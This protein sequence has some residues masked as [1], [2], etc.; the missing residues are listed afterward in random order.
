MAIRPADIPGPL[1]P[2]SGVSDTN[3]SM[4]RDAR[5]RTS[6]G[7]HRDGSEEPEEGAETA[8]GAEE[9]HLLDECA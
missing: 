3:R 7:R 4:D 6:Y 5:E 1:I 8:D 2:L 9:P